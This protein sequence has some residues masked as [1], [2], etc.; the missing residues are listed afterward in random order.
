MADIETELVIKK[1]A[2]FY[3]PFRN[4]SYIIEYQLFKSHQFLSFPTF[5]NPTPKKIFIHRGQ[6]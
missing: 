2:R 1:R 5:I 3:L 6:K 4:N